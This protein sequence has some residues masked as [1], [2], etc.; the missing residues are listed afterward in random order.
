MVISI[1]SA[2]NFNYKQAVTVIISST[3]YI[4]NYNEKELINSTLNLTY[5]LS[6]HQLT[7]RI[8]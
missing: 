6:L 2:I 4:I 8:F 3:L 5:P 7:A 1:V